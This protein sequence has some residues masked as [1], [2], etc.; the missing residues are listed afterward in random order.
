MYNFQSNFVSS[1]RKPIREPRIERETKNVYVPPLQ[2]KSEIDA[3][4]SN[5][6]NLNVPFRYDARWQPKHQPSQPPSSVQY[7]PHYAGLLEVE[8]QYNFQVPA[9]NLKPPTQE[10][11]RIP[12]NHEN[13]L[14]KVA[15]NVD[16]TPKVTGSDID[17][18]KKLSTLDYEVDIQNLLN[19]LRSVFENPNSTHEQQRDILNQAQETQLKLVT[20]SPELSRYFGSIVL[21]Y[22]NYHRDSV[23]RGHAESIQK[24]PTKMLEQFIRDEIARSAQQHVESARAI[25]AMQVQNTQLAQMVKEMLESL[26]ATSRVSRDK[27]VEFQEDKEEIEEPPKQQEIEEP[28]D[29]FKTPKRVG[30]MKKKRQ[31]EQ[32]DMGKPSNRFESLSIE[33]PKLNPEVGATFITG[34]LNMENIHVRDV[35]NDL[36]Q[37]VQQVSDSGEGLGEDKRKYISKIVRRMKDKLKG[38]KAIGV[39][40][41]GELI[42]FLLPERD[43]RS[44]STRGKIKGFEKAGQDQIRDLLIIL[45][46]YGNPPEDV[47]L[48]DWYKEHGGRKL[49]SDD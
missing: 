6:P 23:Q 31:L 4:P 34:N 44:S 13:D 41:G 46:T 25:E 16:G 12:T 11:R 38:K 27:K 47:K 10:P 1:F 42:K 8:K 32:A 2:E 48:T 18:A 15:I 24:E 3:F 30:K 29:G 9:I 14:S 26:K 45:L 28:V 39:K 49:K 5:Y 21:Q 19:A 17:L 37:L 35:D 22:Q 36:I 33:K 40:K 7:T 20:I 43:I